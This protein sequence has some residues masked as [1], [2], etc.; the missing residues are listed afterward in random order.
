MRVTRRNELATPHGSRPHARPSKQTRRG[1]AWGAGINTLKHANHLKLNGTQ[2][3]RFFQNNF[4]RQLGGCE[5]TASSPTRG[6]SKVDLD[7]RRKKQQIFHQEEKPPPPPSF[8]FPMFS[9]KSASGSRSRTFC[10]H[11]GLRLLPPCLL[12]TRYQFPFVLALRGCAAPLHFLCG[13]HPGRGRPLPRAA[14]RNARGASGRG[15]ACG[16]SGG[17]GGRSGGRAGAPGRGRKGK[18]TWTEGMHGVDKKSFSERPKTTTENARRLPCTPPRVE[19][20]ES[21][22][23]ASSP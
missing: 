19:A 11:I 3:S 10:P 13:N 5:R 15:P 6:D 9:F 7:K 18:R 23:E 8:P 21:A 17:G 1:G 20:G 4:K 22:R 14:S 2:S 12:F 16:G